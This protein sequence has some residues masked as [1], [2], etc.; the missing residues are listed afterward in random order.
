MVI[1]LSLAAVDA[2][3]LRHTL[4]SSLAAY[5]K[6]HAM[7]A[8]GAVLRLQPTESRAQALTATSEPS[9]ACGGLTG[10]RR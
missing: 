10:F 9:F 1:G 7:R 3:W 4:V 2:C 8:G 5:T 6:V